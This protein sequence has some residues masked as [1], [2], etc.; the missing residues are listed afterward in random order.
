VARHERWALYELA[1][2]YQR[3]MSLMTRT[4]A[5]RA[6]GKTG[7]GSRGDG[8]RTLLDLEDVLVGF[9]VPDLQQQLSRVVDGLRW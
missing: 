6:W 7:K 9:G 2:G 5:H 1:N 4:E 8:R 3:S